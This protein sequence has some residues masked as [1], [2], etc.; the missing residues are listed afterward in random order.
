MFRFIGRHIG[1]FL[2]LCYW[3]CAIV[4]SWILQSHNLPQFETILSWVVTLGCTGVGYFL[5]RNY[6]KSRRVQKALA[7]SVRK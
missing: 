6:I 5:F 4:T 1:I 2:A 7:K 3:G